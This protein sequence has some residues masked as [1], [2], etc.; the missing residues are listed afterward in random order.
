MRHLQWLDRTGKPLGRLPIASAE[1]F[2]PTLSH[3]GRRAAVTR[4]IGRFAAQVFRVD[5][6]RGLATALT[7][8]RDYNAAGCW[9]PDDRIIALSS[10]QGGGQEEISLVPA[11]GSAPPHVVPTSA[12]QFKTPDSWAADGRNLVINQIS[13]E[14]ARDLYIVDALRGGT[15]RQLSRDPGSQLAA[16]LSPDGHWLAYSS[17]E[18]GVKQ[19]FIRR[20]PDGSDKLQVTTG[21]GTEAQWTR[22]GHELMFLGADRRSIYALAIDPGREPGPDAVQLLFRVPYE[23]DLFGWDVTQDGE[24]LLVLG[25]DAPGHEPSTTIIVDWL[26]LLN[27]R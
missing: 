5:L 19:V 10:V 8:A 13:P 11:D 18:T 20:F 4:I 6:E 7:D 23:L 1:F 21:G 9:S 22:G 24:R 16:K 17:D 14:S 12:L 26:S 15:P 3:D 25:P 2:G 27:R